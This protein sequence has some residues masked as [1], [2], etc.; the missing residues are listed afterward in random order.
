MRSIEY[1]TRT[2]TFYGRFRV[3]TSFLSKISLAP[4]SSSE[5]FARNNAF[6]GN[7]RQPSILSNAFPEPTNFMESS[8]HFKQNERLLLFSHP[9]SPPD[10]TVFARS[11][12]QRLPPWLSH[13][14]TGWSAQG[15]RTFD[16]AIARVAKGSG[17]SFQL[18]V[19]QRPHGSPLKDSR[20]RVGP[21]WLKPKLLRMIATLRWA[22]EPLGPQPTGLLDP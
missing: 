5:Y 17:A 1:C 12:P 9:D 2:N 14:V 18:A 13:G 22:P 11:F 7:I 8:T 16:L 10:S 4:R 15:C 6:Y 3:N 21:K 20:R 19:Q